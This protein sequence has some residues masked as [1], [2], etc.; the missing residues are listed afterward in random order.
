MKR[1]SGMK[2]MS[3]MSSTSAER[4]EYVRSTSAVCQ[5]YLF[6]GGPHQCGQRLLPP[7]HAF[8]EVKH[9]EQRVSDAI[10]CG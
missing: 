6:P 3:G 10:R 2:R 4:Q 8:L 5:E 1:K 9:V 7:L